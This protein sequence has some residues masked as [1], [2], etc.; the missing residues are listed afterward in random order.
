VRHGDD[1]ERVR[2]V[3]NT[4][5]SVVP[6]HEGRE[7]TEVSTGGVDLGRLG[8]LELANGQHQEGQV[9]EEEEQEEG[10]GGAQ[11][12]EQEDGGE[13]EPAGEVEAERGVE[14]DGVLVGADDVEAGGQDDGVGDPEAAVGGERGGTKG[15]ADGHFPVNSTLELVLN[16]QSSFPKLSNLPH[17]GQQLDKTSIAKS[18]RKDDLGEGHAIDTDVNERQDESRQGESRQTKGRRVGE[19][20]VGGR[21]V[22]TRLEFTTEGRE[23]RRVASVHV[24]EWVSSIIVWSTHNGR[25]R[26]VGV[27]LS[28]KLLVLNRVGVHCGGGHCVGF[29]WGDSMLW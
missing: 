7:E 20:A 23:S 13:D 14:H 5:E 22:Q 2:V 21:S 11:G 29:R 17:A 8:E 24:R 19:L 28:H 1:E 12:A 4:G 27:V 9:E 15:V 26:T 6:R 3:R 10:D 16:F 25:V 18:E